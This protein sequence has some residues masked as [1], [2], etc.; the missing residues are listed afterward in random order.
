MNRDVASLRVVFQTLQ[1]TEAGAIGQ[2]HVE[3]DGV[4][5]V[6]PRQLQAFV[7]ARADQAG[8]TQ[9]VRQVE[10]NAGEAHFILHHQHATP[11]ALTQ[12]LAIIGE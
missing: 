2:A 4:R 8:V 5:A 11:T 7:G 1:H 9:F 12:V 3:Q 6:L 10:E